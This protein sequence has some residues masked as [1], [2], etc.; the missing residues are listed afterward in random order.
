M[1]VEDKLKIAEQALMDIIDPIKAMKR[2][3][4]GGYE[5]NGHMAYELS[6]DPNYLKD[7]ASKAL[8]EIRFT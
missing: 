8:R 7:S 5:L 2:D 4:K 6:N 3:L 1:S